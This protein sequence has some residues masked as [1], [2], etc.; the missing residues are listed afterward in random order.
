[1]SVVSVNLIP[2]EQEQSVQSNTDRNDIY[3]YLV[4]C[5]SATDTA[6]VALNAGS[7][8]TLG[9]TITAHTGTNVI[10]LTVL[11]RDVRRKDRSPFHF[12]VRITAGTPTLNGSNKTV[13]DLNVDG[14]KYFYPIYTNSAGAAITN[15][16]GDF[17][18]PPLEEVK[19]DERI[20]VSFTSNAIDLTNIDACRQKVNSGSITMNVVVKGNTYNRTFAAKTL[21][22]DEARYGVRLGDGQGMWKIDYVFLYRA[23]GW[24]RKVA[25]LG[26]KQVSGTNRFDCIDEKFQK[27]SQPMPLA[28]NGLQL[29][30]GIAPN[31]IDVETKTAVSFTGLFTGL[32]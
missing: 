25:N 1:M 29:L 20:S 17:F 14:V 3:T 24:I 9:S 11:D 23:D 22:L 12:I 30:F 27:C 7:L 19:D 16:A 18:D 21:L 8:P 10:G 4:E 5:S 13:V 6:D 32:V 31:Y 26:W 28:T 15:A 2:N